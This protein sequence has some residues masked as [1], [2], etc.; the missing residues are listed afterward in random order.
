[1][2]KQLGQ[3]E[4]TRFLEHMLFSWEWWLLVS[5]LTLPWILFFKLVDK[6]RLP[7]ILLVGFFVFIVALMADE[8]GTETQTWVYRYRTTPFLHTL[9]P[10]D[11]TILPVT[12]M[13]IYQYFTSWKS[14]L[15]A[16]AVNALVFAFVSEPILVWLNIYEPYKW[17][18]LYS[19]P[20]YILIG[21]YAKFVVQRIYR[22]AKEQDPQ[23]R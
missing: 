19:Y 11:F 13:L 20:V 2:E 6:K 16:H 7:E 23:Y 3:M 15:K 8:I 12:Y 14:Y 9:I 21:V 22:F 18:H 17:A 4:M 10:Y 5:L 1:M